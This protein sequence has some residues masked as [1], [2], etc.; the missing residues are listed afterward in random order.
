M[1]DS[2]ISQ[3]P[4][5]DPSESDPKTPTSRPAHRRLGT[6]IKGWWEWTGQ[7]QPIRIRHLLVV[8]CFVF[9]IFGLISYSLWSF[10]QND[11]AADLRD[12]QISNFQVALSV[13]DGD[14]REYDSCVTAIGTRDT[15]RTVFTNFAGRQADLARNSANSKQGIVDAIAAAL[16]ESSSPTVVTLI[17]NLNAVLISEKVE[18]ERMLAEALT[19]IQTDLPARDISQC[20][21]LP[22]RPT[23]ELTPT[24]RGLIRDAANQ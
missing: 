1:T 6:W 8:V 21:P 11:R 23:L 16:A 9:G 5:S 13:Y 18:I 19:E 17:Q 22:K 20:P 3:A 24:E 4:S 15:F 12:Q 10:Y 2:Q 14:L 7:V